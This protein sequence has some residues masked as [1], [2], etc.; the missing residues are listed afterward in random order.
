MEKRK[1]SLGD[2][3]AWFAKARAWIKDSKAW[4]AAAA[5]FRKWGVQLFGLAA[6]LA[7]TAIIAAGT[8]NRVDKWVQDALFQ[9]RGVPSKDIVLIGID[10]ETLEELGPYGPTYRNYMAFA[11]EKLA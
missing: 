9:Q 7:V 8:L 5:I 1:N 11:L 10:E 2:L 6:V 4:Q 3:G